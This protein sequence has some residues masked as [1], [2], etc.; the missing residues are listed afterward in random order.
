MQISIQYPFAV[1]TQIE[2]LSEALW[3]LAIRQIIY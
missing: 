1:P 2:I 3:G